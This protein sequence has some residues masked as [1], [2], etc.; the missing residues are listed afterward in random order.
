MRND[1]PNSHLI[2]LNPLGLCKGRRS[3]HRETAFS[4]KWDRKMR[5]IAIVGG[6][7][8]VG[9]YVVEKFADKGDLIRIIVRN[10]VAA[11]FLK[12]LGEP[13]QIIPVQASLLSCK[14]IA[15]T[16]QG[17]DV[18]VN[19]VGILYEKGSQTFEALHV[20]GASLVA[21][22]AAELKVPTLLH[23]SALG[24]N[25]ESLSR[26]ASTKARGEEA[27]LNYFPHAT[28]FRPSVIFG[29]EDKFLNKFA[30][31]ALF[32][33]FL[34]LIGGG[35]T[36]FQPIYVG[37][38][39]ESIQKASLQKEARG[40]ICELGGPVIYTFSE[41]MKFLL[42][43]IHRKRFLLPL[44]F[45]LAKVIAMLTQYLPTPPLT[46]DQVELLKTDTVVSPQ[47]FTIENFG[48][49]PKALEALA[50]LYLTRYCSSGN[51]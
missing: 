7:G 38:V 16:I 17:A 11:N 2:A 49:R 18:V 32:S 24:A 29:S 28:I 23:M 20:K 19:L 1:L 10:P 22:M 8:F 26:Y 13:G 21:Q 46:L 44:P 43:T 39:A 15:R 25:K 42:K 35:K 31:M 3:C 45:N 41:L 30:E 12:P 5:T 14:D 36:R 47:A 50:P 34:P 48:V 6:S 40:H 33:P 27:V 51:F 4:K 37:D 9:R